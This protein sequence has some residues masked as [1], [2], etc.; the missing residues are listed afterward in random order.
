MKILLFSACDDN[1]LHLLLDM[2]ESLG[3][4]LQKYDFGLL[5]L[6]LSDESKGK[7]QK[8]KPDVIFKKPKWFIDLPEYR[9]TVFSQACLSRPFIKGVFPDYDGYMQIDADLWFLDSSA[10]DDY[11]KAAEAT[12]FSVASE[13]HD[14]VIGVLFDL[15]TRK[16]RWYRTWGR[17]KKITRIKSY[18]FDMVYN[19]FGHKE[20]LEIGIKVPFNNGLFFIHADSPVWEAWQKTVKSVNWKKQNKICDQTCLF[21]A[22]HKYNLPHRFLSIHHNWV[23][24]SKEFLIDKKNGRLLDTIYPHTP[25]KVIHFV[26]KKQKES[27]N[28]K[29]TDGDIITTKLTRRELLKTIG[30][31]R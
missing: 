9:K 1:Y 2:M 30:A 28:I 19:F 4:Q 5:D 8:L 24:H 12:G 20:A 23:T 11:I 10:I 26:C 16:K 15:H 27:H 7:I 18:G 14:S 31:N 22:L 6:G 3:D 21:Y 29:T 13:C 25:I 17:I